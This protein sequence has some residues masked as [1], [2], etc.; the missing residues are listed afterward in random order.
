MS[1][2]AN[3][4]VATM[5]ASEPYV[6]T[7]SSIPENTYLAPVPRVSIQAFCLNEQTARTLEAAG[8]DRRMA[9]AHTKVHL[10]GIKAAI[11]HFSQAPTPNLIVIE[12]AAQSGDVLAQLD[13]LAEYCDAGTRVIVIGDLNDVKLYRDLV[14]AGVSDYLVTPVDIYQLIGSVS[15]LYADPTADPLGRAVAFFGVKG[16]CGSSTVA[17]NTGWSIS[18]QFQHD[19]VVADLDLPFGTAGLDFNQDPIQGIHEAISAPDRLDQ[20]LLDR[21]LAKCSEHLSLLAAPAT[22]DKTYDHGEAAFE[23]LLD[24]MRASTP[25][26][27][28]DVPHVWNG[29]TRNVLTAAD[30]VVIVAEPDLANLRNAK[31]VVDVLSQLRPNDNAPRLVI[32]R[33]NVPKRPEIKPDEFAAALGLELAAEIPFEPQLFGTA[34]NNGQMIAEIN[35]KHAISE[36]FSDL[37]NT[38]LGK[39]VPTKS[40]KSA[41]G[42]LMAKLGK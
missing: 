21:I 14:Q 19:V 33:V 11:E 23:I 28:L 42:S 29:W 9:K 22:L 26:I 25:S 20:T 5:E 17:H 35:G 36:T 31:N 6:G 37:A 4:T 1:T 41:L 39:A 13:M 7:P 3:T 24:V 40:K 2:N 12:V 30:E 10:G 15:N 38:V 27:V 18:R 32:N 16:G 34:A 8:E